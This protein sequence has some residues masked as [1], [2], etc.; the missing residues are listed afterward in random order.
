[1]RKSLIFTAILFSASLSAENNIQ[2]NSITVHNSSETTKQV[3][4][5]GESHKIE[6]GNSLKIK[7]N[8]S[9]LEVSLKQKPSKLD[10]LTR[11]NCLNVPPES[12]IYVDWIKEW[13]ND[14]P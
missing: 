11:H 6:T 8:N 12:I 3:W 13:K 9:I 10:R 1:M 2:D 7:K 5:S 14:L 4:V